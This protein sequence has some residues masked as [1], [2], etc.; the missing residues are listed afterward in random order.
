MWQRKKFILTG[1]LVLAAV[2]ATLGG[3]ALAQ[4][5][6]ESAGLVEDTQTA[7]IEKVAEIYQANTGTAIDA[8]ELE[9]AFAQAREE[10]M[11]E[12]R[13][14]FLDKLV[15]EGKITQEEA[16]QWKA[17][18]DAR[19]DIPSLGDEGGMMFGGMHN[20]KGGIGGGF[21]LK[22]GGCLSD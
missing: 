14:Q 2:V 22:F 16:D 6:D 13:D 18:L 4:A 10:I 5:D 8:Q 17:W 3:V 1:A 7:L 20:G 11:T 15:E 12:T 19:P 9:N 21:G